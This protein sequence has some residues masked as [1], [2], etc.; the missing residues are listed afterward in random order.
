MHSLGNFMSYL[1]AAHGGWLG[2]DNNLHVVM[3]IIKEVLD[4][5]SGNK[6]IRSFVTNTVSYQF[7]GGSSR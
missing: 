5:A 7:L 4:S 3:L 1:D 6:D 2:W